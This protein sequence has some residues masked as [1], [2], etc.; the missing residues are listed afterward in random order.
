VKAVVWHTDGTKTEVED[1]ML[2]EEKIGL[3][4]L[5]K[6]PSDVYRV[7]KGKG[8]ITTDVR[9]ILRIDIVGD[10]VRITGDRGEPVEGMVDKNGRFFLLGKVGIGTFEIGF[11][12]IRTVTLEH[13]KGKQLHCDACRRFYVQDWK[14]CPYEGQRLKTVE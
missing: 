7:V 5:A 9:R 13:P 6:V 1:L 14:Y 2:Q 12:D 4:S 11:S 3:L 8:T 10:T